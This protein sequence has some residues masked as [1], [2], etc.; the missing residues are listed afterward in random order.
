M[1]RWLHPAPR[2][3]AFKYPTYRGRNYLVCR[4]DVPS[5]RNNNL[6]DHSKHKVDIIP[7]HSSERG[8]V[9]LP[10]AFQN[11][12]G[13]TCLALRLEVVRRMQRCAL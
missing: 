10:C 4:C 11:L 3:S 6:D 9:D 7:A 12:A 13:V 1:G 8:R 2:I 5:D